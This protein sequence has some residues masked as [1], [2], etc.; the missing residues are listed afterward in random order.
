MPV[1]SLISRET[2]DHGF[3]RA[4]KY[5]SEKGTEYTIEPTPGGL[6][7]VV[8]HGGGKPATITGEFF[9]SH[10]RARDALIAYIKSTD[11]L[12][13]AEYPDKPEEKKRKVVKRGTEQ[14]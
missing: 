2:D 6:Y 4:E 13:Y 11:R 10:L 12:G 1:L 7:T 14:E 5:V 9:T 8:T 3:V